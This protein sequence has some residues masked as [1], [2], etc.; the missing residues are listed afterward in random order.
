MKIAITGGAGYIGMETVRQ[1]IKAGH[2]PVIID[3]ASF[4]MTKHQ[5]PFHWLNIA[6]QENYEK[7]VDV[8]TGCDAVIHLAAEKDA[9]QSIRIPLL[10]YWNNLDSTMAIIN[11]MK[12]N[13]ISKIIYSSTCAIYGDKSIVTE[14][15]P[16][17]PQTPYAKSK[18]WCEHIIQDAGL[19]H[20]ILRYF[21]VAGGDQTV[22][23]MAELKK[24]N[25]KI[26]GNKY[27]TR[28]GTC[29][30]DYIHVTDVATAHVKAIEVEGN[31]TLNIGTG[32]GYSVIQ[33]LDAYEYK[34]GPIQF[35]IAEPRKGD[36]PVIY[37]TSK[38]AE[39]TL[40]WKAMKTLDDMV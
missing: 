30:R 11:A 15:T 21:N 4:A 36:V 31:H 9:N 23:L 2:E 22:G 28:D 29:V 17:D 20:I 25:F 10:Y 27:L 40:G 38:K 19:D 3:K 12:V 26:Y 37:N 34:H 33:V 18:Y 13:G 14:L 35:D 8:L 5:H 6:W 39:Q 7:L 24:D 16:P 1:L 32:V